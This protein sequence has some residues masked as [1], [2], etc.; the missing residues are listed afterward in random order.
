MCNCEFH[1]INQ[2]TRRRNIHC[3]CCPVGSH[4]VSVDSMWSHVQPHQE[5][6]GFWK[7]QLIL[8][9]K[10]GHNYI[11]AI[12]HVIELPPVTTGPHREI[13]RFI[14]I[15]LDPSCQSRQ[16]QWHKQSCRAKE[17]QKMRKTDKLKQENRTSKTEMKEGCCITCQNEREEHV[18]LEVR[19]GRP[20]RHV[21]G[22]NVF[23]PL[24]E[25]KLLPLGQCQNIYMLLTWCHN[26]GAKTANH[27]RNSSAW[28]WEVFSYVRENSRSEFSPLRESTT[29]P[30]HTS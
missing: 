5:T 14:L 24:P 12:M 6:H 22:W 16:Q 2:G 13:Y 30:E 3:T 7:W 28:C 20:I 26:G 11:Q 21:C 10:L 8:G 27:N 15:H 23:R 18:C 19:V 29:T 4:A 9:A 1:W 25:F 17:R